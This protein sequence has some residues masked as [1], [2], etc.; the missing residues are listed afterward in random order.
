MNRKSKK[1]RNYSFRESKRL[2]LERMIEINGVRIPSMPGSCYHAIMCSLAS[3]KDKFIVW[4]RLYELVEKYMCQYGGPR[5]WDR[6]KNKSNAKTYQ[7]RIK[8]NT[9]TL[10]RTG[11]D[12]YGFRLHEQGMAIYF[13][14]DGAIL[15]TGG[16]YH[17]R[18]EK[19]DVSF[20]DGRHLQVR[21]RGTT[22]TMK[23]YKKFLELNLIDASGKILDHPAI[24]Q[25]RKESHEHDAGSEVSGETIEV[26]IVLSDGFDQATANR[27]EKLGLIV[28]EVHSNEVIGQLPRT[29]LAE[30]KND[31]DVREVEIAGV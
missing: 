1:I 24:R 10:T 29:R 30:L 23:E 25:L 2:P 26:C 4:D 3:H 14:K 18:G 19:Y 9:H 15:F 28:D 11:K 22:M 6:F 31:K 27:L 17:K 7:Q 5:C 20:P 12:C 16:T 21:Y 13:F 8:D